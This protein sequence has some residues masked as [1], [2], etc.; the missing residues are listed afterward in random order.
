MLSVLMQYILA[1]QRNVRW[2][3]QLG[4]VSLFSPSFSGCFHDSSF[5]GDPRI[6]LGDL[7]LQVMNYLS[8][9]KNK[10]RNCIINTSNCT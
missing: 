6:F 9:K 4:N 1:E 8:L 10:I 5:P 2:D 7:S 3:S